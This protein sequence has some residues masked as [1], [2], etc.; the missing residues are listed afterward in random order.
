M[1]ASTRGKRK[2]CFTTI[3][4]LLHIHER[5]RKRERERG[6]ER[7]REEKRAPSLNGSVS[8]HALSYAEPTLIG[9]A[10]VA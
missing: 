5:E 8:H 9:P 4:T 6:K 1:C 10:Q 2:D 3:I 7:K